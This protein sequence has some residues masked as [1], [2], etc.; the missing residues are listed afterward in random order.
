MVPGALIRLQQ[1]RPKLAYA[2]VGADHEGQ[3]ER[4]PVLIRIRR[5]VERRIRPQRAGRW[6]RRAERRG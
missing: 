2:A 6:R 3:R 4:V 5:V 1:I